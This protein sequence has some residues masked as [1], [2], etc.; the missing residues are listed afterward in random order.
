MNLQTISGDKIIEV[1][2]R[3]KALQE[4]VRFNQ[5]DKIG[6]A[7]MQRS[8]HFDSA[9]VDRMKPAEFLLLFPNAPV[10]SDFAAENAEITAKQ[11]QLTAAIAAQPANDPGNNYHNYTVL[12]LQSK[13]EELQRKKQFVIDTYNRQKVK[14]DRPLT[15]AEFLQLYPEPTFT[16]EN[17]AIATANTECNKLD[18]F[19]KS[20]PYPQY[21]ATYD[22]DL[23]AGTAVSA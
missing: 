5:N 14:P 22:V 19:L 8:N 20:G 4:I 15:E 6:Y 3:I 1:Q 11:T 7:R 13:I 10:D 18:A 17:A 12:P 9:M 23:L 2:N 21:P 16:A